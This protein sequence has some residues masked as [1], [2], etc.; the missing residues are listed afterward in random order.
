MKEKKCCTCKKIKDIPNFG[1]NRSNKDGYQKQCKECRKEYAV[2]NKD[3]NKEYKKKY[4]KE[5]KEMID[6]KNKKYYAEN[7]ENIIQY[8]KEWYLNNIEYCKE[9]SKKYYEENKEKICIKEKIYREENKEKI[10]IKTK[11][12]NYKKARYK[13][14]NEERL[15]ID[16]FPRLA[17]DGISLEVKCKY[18]GKYFIPTNLQVRCRIQTLNNNKKRSHGDSFLYCSDECKKECPI[19][20]QIKYP[21][22]YKKTTSREVQ[23]ELRQLVLK[24]DNWTCVKCG[25]AKS[26]HCHHILPLNESP[27]ES[28]DMNNCVILCKECHKEAHKIPDCNYYELGCR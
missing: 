28:A 5:N 4:Y 3:K 24:R 26:L 13:T 25:N 7:E 12:R 11:K 22:G 17:K 8:K 27:I 23:P 16:E 14:Y 20:G 1:K 18:C 21:K 9:I 19:Y 10:K 6:K 15:T 2:K